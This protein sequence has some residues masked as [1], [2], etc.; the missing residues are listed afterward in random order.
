MRSLQLLLQPAYQDRWDF[1][2]V[3]GI[4]IIV[5]GSFGLKG[6]SALFVH[7]YD[8][9]FT[10]LVT[11]FAVSISLVAGLFEPYRSTSAVS[12]SGTRRLSMKSL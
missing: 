12:R 9:G 11:T 8:I 2:Y 7:N 1:S 4:L 6:L 5:P 10:A 3:P